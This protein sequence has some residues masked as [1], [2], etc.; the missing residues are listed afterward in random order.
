MLDIALPLGRPLFLGERGFE[1]NYP[2]GFRSSIA[3]PGQRL[4]LDQIVAI[5]GAKLVIFCTLLEIIVAVGHAQ[6]AL[7]GG[8]DIAGGI[9]RVG[10][11][12]DANRRGIANG[13]EQ[14]QQA[15]P[16]VDGLDFCEIGLERS[17]ALFFDGRLIHP[18]AVKGADFL[19]QRVGLVTLRREI[20]EDRVDLVV[21]PFA[22]YVERAVARSVFRDIHGFEPMAVGVTEKV[23]ARLYRKIAGVEFDTPG[24]E[25]GLGGL[26]RRCII[27]NRRGPLFRQARHSRRK[28]KKRS[29][30]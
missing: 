20:V 30:S 22:Q 8:H 11:D 6:T 28:S 10:Q 21:G 12:A 18:G 17:G 4:D 16:V 14:F 3:D 27:R 5:G 23:R 26:R 7:P 25:L 1:G 9:G 15:G 13:S 29:G 19:I 24:T 2:V